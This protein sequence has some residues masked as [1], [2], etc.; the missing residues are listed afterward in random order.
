[1]KHYL[2]F[3]FSLL[4]VSSLM[5]EESI[6][7][8]PIVVRAAKDE[9]LAYNYTGSVEVITRDQIDHTPARDI[10]GLLK[11]IAGLQV[12]TRSDGS[13]VVDG[14]G[15]NNGAGNGSRVILLLNGMPLKNGDNGAMDWS[16]ISLE[17]VE[18]VEVIRGGTGTLY[19]DGAIAGVVN[20]ITSD[21]QYPSSSSLKLSYGSF[22]TFGGLF[23]L[24]KRL[25]SGFYN[26][27]FNYGSTS[28]SRRKSENETKN[29][30]FTVAHFLNEKTE[31]EGNFHYGE[32]HYNFPTAITSE[33]I[34]K[35]TS[36]FEGAFPFKQNYNIFL[37]HG[38]LSHDY[39]PSAK[40]NLRLGYKDRKYDYDTGIGYNN[41]VLTFELQGMK[42]I[43]MAW[44]ENRLFGGLE[45]KKE[46]I[47]NPD[48]DTEGKV[49]G[50]Y[51]KNDFEIGKLIILDVGYR[52]DQMENVY[53]GA[54]SRHK[55]FH[56]MDSYHTGVLFKVYQGN[57][58]Y[59]NYARCFRIP[60]RDEIV[61]YEADWMTYR[62]TNISLNILSPEKADNYELGVRT[63]PADFMRLNAGLFYMKV[64]DEIFVENYIN[65]NFD[66]IVHQ[67]IESS[68][69][70]RP[71]D[72][73]QMDLS[74]TYQ[75][76]FF[77]KG[78]YKDNQVPLSPENLFSASFSFFPH[79]GFI[80]SHISRWRDKVYIVDDLR[81]E[82]S[83]IKSFWVSDVKLMY[84]NEKG[85]IEFSIYN[86]YNEDYSEWAGIKGGTDIGYF[87]SPRRNYELSGSLYF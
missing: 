39:S 60:S 24:N 77:S 4:M 6:S 41:H 15:F 82:F 44:L 2:I 79:Q 20:I 57:S 52:F 65:K 30:K 80:I 72:L 1:M 25:Q 46:E 26:L 78:V 31:I 85:R 16:L 74:Y 8:E 62:V 14:R 58:F 36:R 17:E 51:L 71:M 5:A 29:V 86:I 83:R 55:K 18:T 54:L 47:F 56:K 81:N 38:G 69:W 75:D 48:V 76:V 53:Q 3:L 9:S 50:I 19:G 61:Q 64:K 12:Y 7:L 63:R 67:G 87:P 13:F 43:K 28:G 66:Q 27:K 84:K 73:A 59:F 45:L 21:S 35:Y 70:I 23:S 42:K 49:A 37:F 32:A 68:A 40:V 10:A 22:N 33:E 34:E 11:T